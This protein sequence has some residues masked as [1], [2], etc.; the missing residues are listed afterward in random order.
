MELEEMQELWSEMTTQLDN[1]KRLTNKL[2]IQMT[3]ERYKS[4]IAILAKYEGVGAMICF[5]AAIMLI[6]QFEML[7]TWYL[8]VSGIFTILYLIIVP[9]V[10]LRSIGFMKRINLA[11]GTYKETLIAYAKGRKQFLLIQKVGIYL[12]FLLLIVSLPVMMKVFSGKDIFIENMQVLYWYI[13]SMTIFLIVF[14][15]WGYG[16]YK[17]VTASASNILADLEDTSL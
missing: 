12:N 16:K 11:K 13:P 3:Q 10:V 7:D 5:V 8:I 4:K 1:Q 2:I 14:S 6:K 15:K 17:K 9:S